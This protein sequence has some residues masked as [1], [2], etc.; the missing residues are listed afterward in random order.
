MLV[1]TRNTKREA[2]EVTFRL[3]L[4]T[5]NNKCSKLWTNQ[6]KPKAE[7]NHILLLEQPNQSRV[8]VIRT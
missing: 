7:I 5:D 6:G 1:C 2:A 8:T 3:L 4:N